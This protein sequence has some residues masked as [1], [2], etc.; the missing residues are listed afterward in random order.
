MGQRRLLVRKPFGFLW[1]RTSL[2]RRCSTR[3]HTRREVRIAHWS[4]RRAAGG[5][6]TRSRASCSSPRAARRGAAWR[7]QAA[8]AERAF[9]CAFRD[10]EPSGRGF[11]HI[12]AIMPGEAPPEWN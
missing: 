9:V 11:V 4:G 3:P 12:D 7:V 5:C 8:D 2:L 10:G 6:S 1:G